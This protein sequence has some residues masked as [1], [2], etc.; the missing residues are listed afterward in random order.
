M[1]RTVLLIGRYA[2][3]VPNMTNDQTFVRG[4]LSNVLEHNRWNRSKHPALMPVVFKLPFGLLLIMKRADIILE[5]KLTVCE[6]DT[7]PIYAFDN[8]GKNAG[9]HNNRLVIFDYG[10]PDNKL[11][12]DQ[13]IGTDLSSAVK[14][15]DDNCTTQES[16]HTNSISIE[17]ECFC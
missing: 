16:V 10:A 1:D 2:I 17:N 9:I 12:D 14:Y 3:K 8:N 4:M 7:L 13:I 15:R 5:R 11:K 6:V